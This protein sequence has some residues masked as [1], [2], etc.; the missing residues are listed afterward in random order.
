MENS[1]TARERLAE[2]QDEMNQLHR[3]L[4]AASGAMEALQDL[5]PK[6]E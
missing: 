2:L 5:L 3:F 6:G 4:V 1:K